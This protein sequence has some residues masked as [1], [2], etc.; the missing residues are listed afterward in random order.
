MDDVQQQESII[1][2]QI[3]KVGITDL[4]Y[5]VRILKKNNNYQHTVANM[6]A[7]VSLP[8]TERGTHMSRFIELLECYK[9]D[10]NR[11]SMFKCLADMIDTFHSDY[12]YIFLSFPYFIDRRSPV[13]KKSSILQIQ[14]S[15]TWEYKEKQRRQQVTV[16]VPVTTLCPCSKQIS[17]YGAH[18]QR[19]YIE[20]ELEPRD[21][22]FIWLEDMIA[23]VESVAS[24][25]IYPL[26][27][28]E[29][30]KHVTEQAYDNP[31][32]VEDIV[33][34]LYVKVLAQY[35]KNAKH[36]NIRVESDESIHQHKAFAQ[37][38]S[39]MEDE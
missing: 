25:P 9:H 1:K 14:C 3:D 24:A 38:E 29:D 10:I 11:D 6:T 31:K 28:R 18:N 2:Q 35:K 13:S 37:L 36:V 16:R 23:L 33:R 7:C 12:G 21:D 8:A 22:T 5:P 19:A 34:E 30:E 32:F 15:F 17:D 26:L 27:K 20:L 39:D 4:S